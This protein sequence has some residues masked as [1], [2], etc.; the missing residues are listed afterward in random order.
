MKESQQTSSEKITLIL[1]PHRSKVFRATRGGSIALAGE[2]D[3][4]GEIEQALEE[5]HCCSRKTRGYG[6]IFSEWVAR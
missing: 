4:L 1:D 5:T 3:D 6:W 2:A